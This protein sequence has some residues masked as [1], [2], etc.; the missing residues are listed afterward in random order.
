MQKT[1]E[2]QLR[3]AE[4]WALKNHIRVYPQLTT[5]TY[6]IRGARGKKKTLHYVNLVL[7]IN[8][9]LHV[10]KELYKQDDEM[11]NKQLEIYNHY[12]LKSNGN[13]QSN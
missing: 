6:E 7:Q 10:G 1:T 2:E 13:D 8:N 9:A 4:S 3:K 11:R 5:S 12:Y